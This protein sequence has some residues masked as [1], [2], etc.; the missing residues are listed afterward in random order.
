[1][2]IYI[3]VI[4]LSLLS[5]GYVYGNDKVI[6]AVVDSGLD[7]NHPEIQ[8]SLWVNEHEIPNNSI[9]DDKNGFVDDIH[10]WD[11]VT[12]KPINKDPNGHGTHIAGIISGK[13]IKKGFKR[14]IAYGAKIMAIRYYAAGQDGESNLIASI[15]AFDYAIENGANIINYSGGGPKPDPRERDII[16]K[17][18]KKNI[19]VIAAAGNFGK[20]LINNEGF[21]PAS[22]PFDNIISVAAND[23][24][25]K[26]ITPSNY[27]IKDVDLSAL[28]KEVFSI[29]PGSLYGRMSGTSQATAQVTAIAGRLMMKEPHLKSSP[30]ELAYRLAYVGLRH[31]ALKRKIATESY[32]DAKRTLKIKGLSVNAFGDALFHNPILDALLQPETDEIDALS[33]YLLQ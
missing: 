33:Q 29:L 24:T 6:I 12:N 1:M 3:T 25:G 9:D 26:L 15:R 19:L 30:K 31:P 23:R 13:G 22:Y 32:L 10:G 28:G 20:N 2:R 17:A 7:L 27:G 4:M 21:Y 16:E 11:F 8:Q 14:G 5:M 18:F